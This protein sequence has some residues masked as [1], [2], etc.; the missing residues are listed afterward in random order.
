MA[1]KL[2]QVC[3][4]GQ[5]VASGRKV[6]MG[7]PGRWPARGRCHLVTKAQAAA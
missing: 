6:A 7:N 2:A 3:G 1:G 5:E 4:L